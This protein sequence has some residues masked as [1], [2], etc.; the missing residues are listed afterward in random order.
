MLERIQ[1]ILLGKDAIQKRAAFKAVL[2][3]VIRVLDALDG[4]QDF[5]KKEK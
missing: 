1:A 3:I 2:N 5:V 4:E